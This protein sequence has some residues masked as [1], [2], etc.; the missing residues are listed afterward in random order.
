VATVADLH[1]RLDSNAIGTD[2]PLEVLRDGNTVRLTVRP[3][4][5][6]PR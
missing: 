1:R 5:R 4:E 3:R 6:A 2:L